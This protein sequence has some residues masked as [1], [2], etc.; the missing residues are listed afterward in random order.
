MIRAGFLR[1]SGEVG[2]K[3]FI[4]STN[5]RPAPMRVRTPLLNGL[6]RP[7]RVIDVQW[8]PCR[9]RQRSMPSSSEG[10][11]YLVVILYLQRKSLASTRRKPKSVTR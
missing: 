11:L 2:K 3:K 9:V 8:S 10:A 1:Q 5:M 4:V 6:P 7:V